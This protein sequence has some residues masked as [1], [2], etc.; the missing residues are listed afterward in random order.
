MK[1]NSQ[2][3]LNNQNGQFVIEAVLLM[4]LSIGLLTYGL[5]VLRDG[6]VMSNMIS[7]PWPRVAG[8]IESGSWR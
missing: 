3:S 8:M 4:V 5:R 7:G 1:R 2:H 6:K